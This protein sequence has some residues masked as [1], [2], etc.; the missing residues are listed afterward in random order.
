[1]L[2]P[3]TSW[4]VP[5]AS[6]GISRS[7]HHHLSYHDLLSHCSH[8]SC[9]YNGHGQVE[10]A[11]ERSPRIMDLLKSNTLSC[12]SSI[13]TWVPPCAPCCSTRALAAST[14]RQCVSP[15]LTAKRTLVPKI[16]TNLAT[17]AVPRHLSGPDDL[18]NDSYDYD[19]VKGARIQFSD[20]PSLP[21]RRRTLLQW[22][23]T[24]RK[25]LLVKKPRHQAATDRL[26]QIGCWLKARGFAVYVERAVWATE[27]K[28]EGFH[29]FEAHNTDV[30]FCITLGGDGEL[31]TALQTWIRGIAFPLG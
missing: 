21:L 14:P 10:A 15:N 11:S 22:T 29:A 13:N 24:P 7:V 28:S 26:I 8:I 17:R 31:C 20:S 1:M 6:T 19:L 25:V 23:H 3:C 27:C 4:V 12:R 2:I 30:D 5:P 16:H 18:E 9:R